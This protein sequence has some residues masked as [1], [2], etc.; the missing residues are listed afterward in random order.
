MNKFTRGG[1][2]AQAQKFHFCISCRHHQNEKF[3]T[4]PKCGSAD[5]VYFP[6][7]T[8]MNRAALLLMLRDQGKVSDIKYHP[9]YELNVNGGK[10]GHYVAD[11]SYTN[12][13]GEFVV[14][15]SKIAK[16]LE[17]FSKWKIRHFQFQYGIEVNIP[18]RKS[19]NIT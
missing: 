13:A 16:H 8:E 12:H 5:R 6:S 10:L 19:G 9:R 14:E 4:C 7:R 15:D 11:V 2:F 3:E 17:P 18:Q 1:R